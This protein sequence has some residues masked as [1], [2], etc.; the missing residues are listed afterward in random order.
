MTQEN[1][2]KAAQGTDCATFYRE[3]ENALEWIDIDNLSDFNEGMVNL[4]YRPTHGEPIAL[5]FVNGEFAEW[6]Y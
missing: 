6:S 5:L 2:I 1:I 4:L 3:H